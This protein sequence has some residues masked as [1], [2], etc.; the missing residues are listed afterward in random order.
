VTASDEDAYGRG[1]EAGVVAGEIA[2]RLAGHDEHFAAING[3]L[4]D[5]AREM[6]ELTLAVQRLADQAEA[7]AATVI[8][9]AKALKDA[10][11]ARRAQVERTWSPVQKLLAVIA[12]LAALLAIAIG[13]RTLG[14]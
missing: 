7:N 1:H 3:S 10:D 12:G 2:T 13:I 5:I 11:E 4:A 14:K 9:T 8:A 6:H